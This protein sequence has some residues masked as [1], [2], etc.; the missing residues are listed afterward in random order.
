[1]NKLDPT[2]KRDRFTDD[3]DRL[4]IEGIN[5]Y[6]AR[7]KLIAIK[8][9]KRTE[10]MVKNRWHSHIKKILKKNQPEHHKSLLNIIKAKNKYK[11]EMEKEE[12]ERKEEERKEE[13]G[14]KKEEVEGK[15]MKEEEGER[16]KE[17]GRVREEEER[18]MEE[19][20]KRIEEQGK[21]EEGGLKGWEGALL[22]RRQIFWEDLL[23]R[24]MSQLQGNI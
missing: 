18:R 24:V 4:I 1:M 23:L 9:G 14:R 5:K 8:I 11:G 16:R 19:E 2:I 17:G 10:N 6:G 21:K 7:W 13:V 3:E 15:R 20:R 22:M 12:K